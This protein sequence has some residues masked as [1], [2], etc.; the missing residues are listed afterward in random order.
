M[1]SDADTETLIQ[2]A[3]TLTKLNLSQGKYWGCCPLPGHNDKNPSFNIDTKTGR[4]K[5]WVCNVSGSDA[6]YLHMEINGSE[7]T[8]AKRA[9]GLWDNSRRAPKPKPPQPPRTYES[10]D[11]ADCYRMARATLIRM[12]DC[13]I[14]HRGQTSTNNAFIIAALAGHTDRDEYINKICSDIGGMNWTNQAQASIEIFTA[15]F[16]NEAYPIEAI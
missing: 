14:T 13:E 16:L 11:R 7:W 8:E 12:R 9:L 3:Q 15:L 1:T 6:I 10:T 2:Y 5:C 4:W